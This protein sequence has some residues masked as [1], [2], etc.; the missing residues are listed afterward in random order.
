M[1]NWYTYIS[2]NAG[3]YDSVGHIQ[4][5]GGEYNANVSKTLV[6]EDGIN[7][8]GEIISTS[9]SA[10]SL[11]T[12]GGL[13][14]AGDSELRGDCDVTGTLTAASVSGNIKSF[15][16]PHPTLEGK[17][18]WHGCLEGPEH[19]VYIRGTMKDTSVINLPDYW[20]D[21]VD[22]ETITVNLTPLGSWQELY[23][24]KIEWGKRV[25]VKS[26]AS[27]PVNCYYTV[28]AMR[29]DVPPLE[30]VQDA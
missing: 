27:G 16:I 14:V 20:A 25:I 11:K 8:P 4:N 7:T 30:I 15:N 13:D 29:K 9:T 18:L 19:A 21:L 2:Q 24:Q 26:G 10:T 12:A 23:V 22:L 3:K 28:T 17:R 6:P 1:A 5:Y